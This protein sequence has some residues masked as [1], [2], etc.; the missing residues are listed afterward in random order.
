VRVAAARALSTARPERA[1]AALGALVRDERRAVRVEAAHALAFQPPEA[2]SSALGPD[3]RA[4]FGRAL[5]EYRASQTARADLPESHLNLGAL[6]AQRGR[7]GA[8]E[9]AY[10]TALGIDPDFL[11]ARANLANL[12]NA[13][14]AI[15]VA[16]R[17]SII[18]R[19]RNLA[20]LCAETYLKQ[21]EDMG[22]PLLKK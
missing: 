17:A 6:D 1:V 7:T 19:V 4:A 13:R 18:G 12:L 2:L 14:G 21:R 22:F 8:A 15:S 9:A 11:P 10:R 5:D 3:E 16:E 20:R